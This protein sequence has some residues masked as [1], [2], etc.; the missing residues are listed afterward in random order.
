MD[1]RP[2]C[3]KVKPS[4]T[5]STIPSA[6]SPPAKS[7]SV[8]ATASNWTRSTWTWWTAGGHRMN[9]PMP[10]RDRGHRS[11]TPWPSVFEWIRIRQP[12]IRGDLD[13]VPRMMSS[14]LFILIGAQQE[15]AAVEDQLVGSSIRRRILRRGSKPGEPSAA[16]PDPAPPRSSGSRVWVSSQR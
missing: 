12:D 11:P 4:A 5:A 9:H 15:G 6:A 13:D 10:A 16:P 3:G 1:Y 8:F 7:P 14:A 2:L